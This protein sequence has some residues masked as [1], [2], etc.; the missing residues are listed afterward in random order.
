MNKY[1]SH[2]WTGGNSSDPARAEKMQLR[3]VHLGHL[4][5]HFLTPV[6]MCE[7][8]ETWEQSLGVIRFAILVSESA[9]PR[10]FPMNPWKPVRIVEGWKIYHQGPAAR[11]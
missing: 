9:V 2:V 11:A 3:W 1:N 7:G 6:G 5:Q 8:G 4:G 10:G